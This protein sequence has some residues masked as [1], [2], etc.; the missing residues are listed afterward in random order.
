M[1][2]L[3]NGASNAVPA[4]YHVCDGTN[5][6]PNLQDKFIV[7][8]GNTYALG[9]TGGSATTVTGATD[10]VS[11]ISIAGHALVQAEMPS[12]NHEFFTSTQCGFAGSANPPFTIPMWSSS[13]G[14]SYATNVPSN[15]TA[16][17]GSPI[18][19]TTGGPSGN[20]G[21]VGAGNAHT[22]SISGNLSHTHTYNLPPYY[23]L[24]YIMKL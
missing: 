5:G 8:A 1:I 21:A 15:A 18:I 19:Q 6:T 17:A 14:A 13:P 11:G 4:G 24:F 23:G 3:W 12:H 2:L 20:G 22:H 7:G 10:P 9:A 16:G